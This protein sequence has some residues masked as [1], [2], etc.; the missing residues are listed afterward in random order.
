M[1]NATR[2]SKLG[3]ALALLAIAGVA[4]IAGFGSLLSSW[5]EL[6]YGTRA[7]AAAAA[8]ALLAG[9]AAGPAYLVV[10]AEGR[11]SVRR[12]L[13]Q[14]TATP[15]RALVAWTSRPDGRVTRTDFPMWFVRVKTTDDVNLGT[16]TSF[17]ARDW[18]NLDLSVTVEDL[19]RRG[20][21]LVLDH[22][23]AAGARLLLWTE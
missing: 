1:K 9:P 6:S 10:S 15:L 23:D 21:G 13:E 4:G 20:P 3:W 12:D 16:L 18:E 14:A 7:E 19:E 5:S 2:R 22:T 11:V 8:A 17:F